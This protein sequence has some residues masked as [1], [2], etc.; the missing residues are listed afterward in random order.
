M[1]GS[2]GARIVT[3]APDKPVYR[4]YLEAFLVA[5]LLAVF[6]RTFLV[7]PF[8]IPTGSMEPNLLVGDHLLVNKF[9]FGP[10]RWDL[11]RRLL[12]LRPVQRGDVVVFKFPPDP[13]R[14]FVKRCVAVAGDTVEIEDKQLRINGAEVDDGSYAQHRDTRV[15]PRSLYLQ[16]AFRKR[17]NFGPYTVPEHTYFCLGDNRDSSHDSR[18]WGPVP[19]S[20]VK[21]RALMVY[22]SLESV[23][24]SGD[25]RFIRALN[26]L[27]FHTRWNRSLHVVR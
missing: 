18:F 8:K 17:D 6:L 26:Q 25:S 27:L 23:S 16:D 12:P 5:V 7:Q 9:V 15:Y 13:S 22:W 2:A 20:L 1:A 11:E 19:Q 4:D 10:S 21:G 14:D 24:E 3:M